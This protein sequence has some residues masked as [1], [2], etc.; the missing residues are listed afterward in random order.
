MKHSSN[1]KRANVGLSIKKL[2][3]QIGR[4]SEDISRYDRRSV[5]GDSC[6][7]Q[8]VAMQFIQAQMQNQD[9]KI[10]FI[11]LQSNDMKEMKKMLKE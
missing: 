1:H 9:H 11:K 4:T 6:L 8:M 10:E 2:C 5:D 7:S 3:E